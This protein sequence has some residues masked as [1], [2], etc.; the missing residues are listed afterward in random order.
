MGKRS[1]TDP[2]I[3]TEGWIILNRLV[4]VSYKV[5]FSYE[6]SSQYATNELQG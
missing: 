2:S 3:M 1:T 5:S 6:S 4:T